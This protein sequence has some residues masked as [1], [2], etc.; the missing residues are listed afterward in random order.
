MDSS[1]L[2]P[3]LRETVNCRIS[4]EKKDLE[5]YGTDWT[6]E[7]I[8]DPLA[9]A[10]PKTEED[11]RKIVLF[12][13]RNK[14]PLIPSGGRTGLSA[15]AVAVKK[16]LVVSFEK[17][18]KV[19]SFNEID[20]TLEVEAGVTTQAV[21]EFAVTKELHYPID[22]AS[23]GSSQIGGNIATNAGGVHVIRY[24]STKNWVKGLKVVTGEGKLLDINMGLTKNAT[25]YN[26]R[27][28]FIGSEGTLGFIVE[29]T[30]QLIQRPRGSSV[31]L[32]GTNDIGDSVKILNLF[33]K[34]VR[35]N[36]FEFFSASSVQH[37]TRKVQK[38]FPINSSYNYY[39]LIDIEASSEPD[40]KKI[41]KV[42]QDAAD[43]DL[44]GEAVISQS[45]SQSADL[46]DLRENITEAISKFVTYKNDVSVKTSLVPRFLSDIE[47]V[48]QREYPPDFR[49][50]LF[51]HIG[52]GNI[53][54]NIL[55]PQSLSKCEFLEVCNKANEKLFKVVAKY[56][57]SISAEHGVGLI[58]KPYLNYTRTTEEINI[59]KKIKRIFDPNNILNPGKIFPDQR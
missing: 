55:K 45:S 56:R 30:L 22:L 14:L 5:V 11:V 46:W 19:L 35:L 36:A 15:G 39:L 20:Q 9:V 28:L 25:G 57:G 32:I 52:D 33:R 43:N 7:F 54:I 44:I 42:Y 47:K 10:F 38:S 1:S 34:K 21:Q 40:L 51:G 26:L 17:M 4:T 12:A 37:V 18:N 2:I 58:K 59:M 48:L 27:D 23:R 29:A 16:E 31:M 24:G 50:V 53:H 6:T 49:T 8:P 13:N 3:E 41:H